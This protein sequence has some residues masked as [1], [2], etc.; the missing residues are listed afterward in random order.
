MRRQKENSTR[1]PR[2]ALRPRLSSMAVGVLSTLSA[3]TAMGVGAQTTPP[4]PATTPPPATGNSAPAAKTA[5]PI[6]RIVVTGQRA[7]IRKALK[8]Q[9][10]ADNI[11][12]AVSSDDIGQLPDTNAAEA[13][14]RIPGLSVERDQGEGRYVSVRGLGADLNSVTING[15]LV[16]APESSRRGVMLDVLPAGLIRSLE[17]SKTLTPDQDAN[18][19]G[20]TIEVKTL[21]AFDLPGRVFNAEAGGSR[22]DNTRQN[23]PKATALFADRLMDGKFG[24]ALGASY[25]KRKF[26]SEN[27]ETGG[28]WDDGKLEEFERRDYRIT[29]EREAF[30]VNL[31]FRPTT[32]SKWFLRAFQSKFSD[33]EVRNAHAIEFADA[34][35]SGEL[36]DAEAVRELK[37]RVE[38]QKIRSFVLGGEQKFGDWKVNLALG[39]SRATEKTPESIGGAVFEGDDDFANTGFT[40][41]R[42]P[43]LIGP[44]SILNASAYELD[45]IELEAN[46]AKD[47][48]RHVKLDF[49]RRMQLGLTDVEL[50]FGGKL[51]RRT[52]TNDTDIWKIGADDVPGSSSLSSF[53]TGSP[54]YRLGAFGPGIDAGSVLSRIAGI[55]RA[56][57]R[58]DEDSAIDDYTMK[59]RIDAAYLMGTFNL[60]PLFVTAG[61]RHERTRFEADGTGITDGN[62]AP[63]RASRSQS[64][65]MPALHLRY[66]LD[67]ETAVRAALTQSVVRPSFGQLAPGFVIDGDEASFGNPN[68][69]ALKSNNL[70]LGVERRLGEVGAVSAYVF[71]K[72]IKNFIYQT[73][74]AGSPGFTNFDE[75]VT[76][77]NGDTARLHGLELSWTQALT[78]LPSP[79]NGLVLGANATFVD[80]RADIARVD[81]GRTVKRR[82]ALPSQSDRVF[83]VSLGYE[84]GPLSVRLAANRKSPYLLEVGDVLDAG[85]DLTVDSQTQVDFQLRY[86]L[87][88]QIQL[89]F[90]GLNLNNEKYYVYQGNTGQNAQYE[91]YGRTYKFTVKINLF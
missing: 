75:A 55:N 19:L 63:V 20:G 73:D 33:D 49:S 70:D 80:S 67:K 5:Q 53:A 6:E 50:K 31:D 43:S 85:K 66:D 56:G 24:V 35:A 7:N 68:L 1:C 21:S 91:Q 74:V 23:G 42:Q 30:S 69:K 18:S 44:T 10:D 16:P 25:D 38:T 59:E 77:V 3:L 40:N 60:S 2:A 37:A 39:A 71:A 52:K 47:T 88:K 78:N 27:V 72:R 4:A 13:L 8:I 61:V 57:F 14:A 11:V 22:D 28:A 76:F 51:S 29:R 15:A 84:A 62:F 41:G 81:G 34:Q 89:G 36:G 9:E 86:R 79:F 65:W 17:V 82:I 54:D 32:D 26:G 48:E 64:D 90:E 46:S 12:S 58:E 83:N 87:T 45:E